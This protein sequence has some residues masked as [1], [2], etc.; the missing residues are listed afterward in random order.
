M[1][2]PPVVQ[3]A[4][5]RLLT[6]TRREGIREHR[7]LGPEVSEH[8]NTVYIEA[9][10]GAVVERHPVANSEAFYVLEGE[11]LVDGPGFLER[12]GPGDHIYF[13]PGYEHGVTVQVGPA[14]F[15]V[16]FAPARSG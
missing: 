13:P 14:R 7:L 1:T 10:E 3:R 8:Q 12:L 5:D 9:E 16:V 2:L 6:P 11:I 4:A 15:L